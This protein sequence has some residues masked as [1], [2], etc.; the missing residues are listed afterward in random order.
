[1]KAPRTSVDLWDPDDGDFDIARGSQSEAERCT[2]AQRFFEWADELGAGASERQS[3]IFVNQAKI[4]LVDKYFEWRAY[5]PKSHR[6]RVR[7]SGHICIFQVFAEAYERLKVL[8]LS[9][10]PPMIFLPS[11][12]TPPPPQSPTTPRIAGIFIG[13]AESSDD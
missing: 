9:L 3:I 7:A 12:A 5:A 1:M 8:E 4:L 13:E 6:D 11:V 10:T 2:F